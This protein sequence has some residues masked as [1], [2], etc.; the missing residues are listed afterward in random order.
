[1]NI[2]LRIQASIFKHS[3]VKAGTQNLKPSD[4]CVSYEMVVK[5]YDSMN[6][7]LQSLRNEWRHP[8]HVEEGKKGTI[9]ILITQQ[10]KL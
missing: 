7:H 5:M 6:K 9:N 1:M 8:N 4:Q 10:N 2:S 3:S